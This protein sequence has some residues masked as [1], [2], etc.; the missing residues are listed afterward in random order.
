MTPTVA[1]PKPAKTAANRVVSRRLRRIRG[2]FRIFMAYK[3]ML[4]FENIKL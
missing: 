2:S 4:I 3:Y 1:R